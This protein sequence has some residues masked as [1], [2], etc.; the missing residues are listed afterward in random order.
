METTKNANAAWQDSPHSDDA[1]FL[2]MIDRAELLR[3]VQLASLSAGRIPTK[4]YGVPTFRGYVMI[5]PRGIDSALVTGAN[6]ET[7]VNVLVADAPCVG[8]AVLEARKLADILGAMTGDVVTIEADHG[9]SLLYSISDGRLGST[10]R[11][12]L[13]GI[14]PDTFPERRSVTGRT[15]IPRATVDRLSASASTDS[16]RYYLN[17]VYIHRTSEGSVCGVATDGHRLAV[18]TLGIAPEAIPDHDPKDYVTGTGDDPAG[19]ILPTSALTIVGK[20]LKD[21]RFKASAIEIGHFNIKKTVPVPGDASGIGRT[22]DRAAGFAFLLGDVTVTGWAIEGEFPD[23]NRVIPTCLPVS[24]RADSQAFADAVRTVEPIGRKMP[25]I[26]G[27]RGIVLTLNGCLAV[28]A[29]S[30]DLG[31]ARREVVADHVPPFTGDPE[32]RAGFCARYLREALEYL[33]AGPVT[34]SGSDELSPLL[35]RSAD[36]GDRKTVVMPCQL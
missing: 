11:G 21:K 13:V 17:G 9:G 6:T 29:S 36:H 34:V 25:E 5:E 1:R 33:G 24:V 2:C 12:R 7:S 8:R 30:R 32:L 14:D 20:I 35:L 3:A 19:Y 23:Y 27:G 18:E 22:I 15:P 31:E 4:T 28:E 16:T 26:R 10:V